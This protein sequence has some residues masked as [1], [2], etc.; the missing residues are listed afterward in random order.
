M[1]S[2]SEALD[3]LLAEV[4]ADKA[5]PGDSM[6]ASSQSAAATAPQSVQPAALEQLRHVAQLNPAPAMPSDYMGH[7]ERMSGAAALEQLMNEVSGKASVTPPSPTDETPQQMSLGQ[8][9]T[10]VAKDVG[11][12]VIETP[13]AIVKGVR[14]AYQSMI[15]L[16]GDAVDFAKEHLPEPPADVVARSAARAAEVG[17]VPESLKLPDIAEPKSVTGNI[18]KNI[19]EF[20][21]SLRAAG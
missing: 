17:N 12:G 3:A 6:P 20:V 9:P 15:D 10:A 16:A 7:V 8:V 13:R 19:V 5:V 2:S 14:D 11:M 4:K 18:E 1:G 21:T